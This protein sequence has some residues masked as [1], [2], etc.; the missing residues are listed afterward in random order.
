ML[1]KLQ[2]LESSAL[3]A[4]DS[5]RLACCRFRQVGGDKYR[6]GLEVLPPGGEADEGHYFSRGSVSR[7]F[8]SAPRQSM[9]AVRRQAQ[10]TTRT[11]TATRQVR[12]PQRD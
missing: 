10:A 5:M 3:A 7:L 11:Q 4:L 12:S 9:V 2:E 6:I 8:A 1:E